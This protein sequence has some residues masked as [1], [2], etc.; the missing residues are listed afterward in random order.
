MLSLTG[1]DQGL[2]MD[3]L[4]QPIPN[5]N[6]D[7]FRNLIFSKIKDK[8][9]ADQSI[10]TTYVSISQQHTSLANGKFTHIITDILS[11]QHMEVN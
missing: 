5:Q 7:D 9:Q 4:P 8:Q 3:E 10:S 11:G 1:L 6:P 2:T